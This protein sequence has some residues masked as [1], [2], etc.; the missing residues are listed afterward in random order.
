[1]KEYSERDIQATVA[2]NMPGM[3][4]PHGVQNLCH[5]NVFIFEHNHEQLISIGPTAGPGYSS[6]LTAAPHAG[7]HRVAFD[8][9]LVKQGEDLFFK[10]LPTMFSIFM[11]VLLNQDTSTPILFL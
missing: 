3:D 9:E 7:N 11:I 8:P 1:M 5:V 2:V 4:P 6:G 10:L